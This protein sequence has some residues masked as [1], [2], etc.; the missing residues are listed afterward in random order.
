MTAN[1]R[2]ESASLHRARNIAESVNTV[3]AGIVADGL[4][5]GFAEGWHPRMKQK[6]IAKYLIDSSPC[7]VSLT[8]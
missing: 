3:D 7:L 5:V 4:V 6:P 2:I 1:V 8:P